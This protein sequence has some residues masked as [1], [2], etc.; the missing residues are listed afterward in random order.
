VAS[1]IVSPQRR[2][3]FAVVSA[4]AFTAWDLFLD[5]QMV[6]RGLWVWQQ[7]GEYFGIPLVNFGGW[8]LASGLVTCLVN[9]REIE[10]ASKPL[11]L[12]YALTWVLQ[13]IGLGVFWGQPGPA[14]FGCVGM[15]IFVIRFWQRERLKVTG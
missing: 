12:I 7:P 10:S 2:L 1:A 8:L 13:T 14:L 6:A 4:F 11:A 5:P 15:G 3:I 9:P